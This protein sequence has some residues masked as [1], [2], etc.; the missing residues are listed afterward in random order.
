MLAIDAKLKLLTEMAFLTSLCSRSSDRGICTPPRTGTIRW[1]TTWYVMP[2]A[3]W[4]EARL[5]LV[6][7]NV[8]LMAFKSVER[9]GFP[10]P[11]VFLYTGINL[12]AHLFVTKDLSSKP[13]GESGALTLWR[14]SIISI[15]FGN[16][17]DH[18]LHVRDHNLG[19]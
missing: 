9:A 15:C 13:S 18:T 5:S 11:S 6:F 8:M 10:R 17:L 2:M 14:A 16:I 19:K 7:S 3:S 12:D 1:R 4:R